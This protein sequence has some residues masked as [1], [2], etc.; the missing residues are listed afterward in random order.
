MHEILQ[1]YMEDYNLSSTVPIDLVLFEDAVSH[2]CR[3]ARIVRQ[4]MA[5]ALL[6]GMGGSGTSTIPWPLGS[7]A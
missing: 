7:L 3:I 5:N 6:L 1:H 4:P 2:L